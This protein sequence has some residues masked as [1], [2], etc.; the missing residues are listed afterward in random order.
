MSGLQCVGTSPFNFLKMTRPSRPDMFYFHEGS[1]V[2][3]GSASLAKHETHL[4]RGTCARSH[5]GARST[6]P[7]SG[8]L[9][10]KVEAEALLRRLSLGSR[11]GSLQV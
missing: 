5:G 11:L 10:C 3:H 1:S 9:W 2:M 7:D 4:R 6:F 8:G